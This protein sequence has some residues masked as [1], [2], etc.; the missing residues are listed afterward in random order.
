VEL[1]RRLSTSS[2]GVPATAATSFRDSFNYGSRTVANHEQGREIIFTKNA[3]TS[4][5]FIV[6]RVKLL[7]KYF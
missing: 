1:A 3:L 5:S 7:K 2:E 6:L 4:S